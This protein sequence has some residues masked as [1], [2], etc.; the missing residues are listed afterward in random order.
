MNDPYKNIDSQ[1][2]IIKVLQY[3]YQQGMERENISMME[4]V[5]EMREKLQTLIK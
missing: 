1:D 5:D 4:L 2:E 3:A